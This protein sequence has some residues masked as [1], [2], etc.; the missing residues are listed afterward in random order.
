MSII[1]NIYYSGQNGNARKFADEMEKSGTADL[2]RNEDGNEVYQYFFPV[3]DSETVLL[4]DKWKDQKS[5]DKHHS[6]DMMNKIIQLREKYDLH[7][8]VERYISDEVGIPK[9]DSKFI[10][11]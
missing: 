9:S 8:K 10:R 5:I 7:M 11:E 2:I 6:S 4:I 3:N 1:V